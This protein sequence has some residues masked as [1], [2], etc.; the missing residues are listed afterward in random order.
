M[1]PEG[2]TGSAIGIKVSEGPKPGKIK[3]IKYIT[4]HFKLS[5]SMSIF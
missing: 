2:L 4:S 5:T 3:K 1:G